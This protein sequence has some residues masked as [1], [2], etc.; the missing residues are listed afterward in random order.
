MNK[1]ELLAHD[2][3]VSM[4]H[5]DFMFGSQDMSIMGQTHEGIEVE[6]FKNGNFCI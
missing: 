2:C 4:V 1:E 3:N 5:S 6:I